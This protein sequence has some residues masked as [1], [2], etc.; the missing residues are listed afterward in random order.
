LS[1]LFVLPDRSDVPDVFAVF[2]L[3]WREDRVAAFREWRDRC[4][5]YLPSASG[6]PAEAC[7]VA[8]EV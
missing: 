6:L 4:L 2:L 7:V 1:A 5:T 3:E 8:V